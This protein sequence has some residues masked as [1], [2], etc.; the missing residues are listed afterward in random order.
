MTGQHQSQYQLNVK[1]TIN[2]PLKR[3]WDFLFSKKGLVIW[4]GTWELDKWETGITFTTNNGIKGIVR[5]F[6]PYS[7]IRLSWQPADWDYATILQLR[8]VATGDNTILLIHQD[9]LNDQAQLT[10]ME[11]YWTNVL[12]ELINSLEVD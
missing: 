1:R 5:V 12:E 8:L 9:K 4:L 6:S 3:V 2:L 11:R 10:K 7:H